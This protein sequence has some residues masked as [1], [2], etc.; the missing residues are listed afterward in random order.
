MYEIGGGTEGLLWSIVKWL[1]F[2]LLFFLFL[3]Y[4]RIGWRKEKKIDY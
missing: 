1:F 2:F 4:F 3:V